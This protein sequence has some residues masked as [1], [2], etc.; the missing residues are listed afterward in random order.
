MVVGKRE[1]GLCLLVLTD[2]KSRI[3]LIRLIKGWKS[4]YVIEE[5]SKIV[6]K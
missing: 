4:R 6:K 2:R 3:K 1:S 5:I